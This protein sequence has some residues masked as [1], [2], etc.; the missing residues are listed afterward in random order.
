M[1][2]T[3]YGNSLYG[4]VRHNWGSDGYTYSLH[5][6]FAAGLP[7]AVCNGFATPAEALET[8]NVEAQSRLTVALRV[9]EAE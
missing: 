5:T 8:M 4:T 6:R 3:E 2:T 7:L 9:E 1:G